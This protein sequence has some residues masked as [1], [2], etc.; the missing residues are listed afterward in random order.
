M[1]TMTDQLGIDLSMEFLMEKLVDPKRFLN[2]TV[3][4]MRFLTQMK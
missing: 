1:S 2:G 4:T 3:C